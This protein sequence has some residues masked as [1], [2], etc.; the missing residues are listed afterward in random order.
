MQTVQQKIYKIQCILKAKIYYIN[1]YKIWHY[2]KI[3]LYVILYIQKYKQL[4]C[5]D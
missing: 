5:E 1:V 3:T 4:I 2:T